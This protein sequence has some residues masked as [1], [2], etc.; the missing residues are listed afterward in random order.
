METKIR[1]TA[2]VRILLEVSLSDTWG[3]D[4]TISQVHK[5]SKDSALNIV[6]QMISGSMRNV[7]PI[8]EP[9]VEAIIA[10]VE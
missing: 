4:C 8:G 9:K 6:S 10:N 5:Q 3:E 2:R 1:T 7:K